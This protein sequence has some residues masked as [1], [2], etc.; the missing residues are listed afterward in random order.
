MRRATQVSGSDWRDATARTEKG[1]KDSARTAGEALGLIRHAMRAASHSGRLRKGRMFSRS[2]VA[3]IR[4][5]RR[6]LRRGSHPFLTS[7][8]SRGLLRQ[9]NPTSRQSRV[10]RP[11]RSAIG[12]GEGPLSRSALSRVAGR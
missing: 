5:G 3:A 8:V 6:S 1:G 2:H 11:S 9:Q 12:A 7:Y 4:L 10:C